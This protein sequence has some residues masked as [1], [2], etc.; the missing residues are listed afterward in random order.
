M[1]W[2]DTMGCKLEGFHTYVYTGIYMDRDRVFQRNKFFEYACLWKNSEK[3][4]A[5]NYP[6]KQE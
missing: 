2:N 6:I 4:R 3:T 1:Y 5:V